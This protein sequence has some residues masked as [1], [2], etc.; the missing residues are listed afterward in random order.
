MVG[1]LCSGVV[2]AL[3]FPE[4]AGEQMRSTVRARFSSFVDYVSAALSGKADRAR[5]EDTNAKFVADIVGFEAVRSV[6]VFE[7]PDSR[8][9]N[10]RLSRLNSEFMTVSTRF[11]ALHQLMNRLR[12]SGAAG[13]TAAVATLEPYFREISPLLSKSGE[14]VLTA[15]DASHAAA[16]LEASKAA[17][18]K[19]VRQE[20]E[21]FGMCGRCA[22][23]A[24]VVR[25]GDDSVAEVSLPDAID[26]DASQQRAGAR[27]GMRQPAGECQPPARRARSHGDARARECPAPARHGRYRGSAPRRR[28]TPARSRHDRR[29]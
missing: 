18:P 6:A 19:R 22:G 9:R 15:A 7:S 16:Q 24:K 14:P 12:V 20:L 4:H 27:V 17:L 8:M 1:I 2:S 23:A 29:R 13:A 11:H 10:G 26:H 25:R 3:V 21:Q 28:D 5:I